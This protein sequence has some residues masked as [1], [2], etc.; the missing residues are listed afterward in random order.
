M[1]AI[2]TGAD[3]VAWQN[4]DIVV[5]FIARRLSREC[6]YRVDVAVLARSRISFLGSDNPGRNAA[7]YGATMD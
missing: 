4:L 3:A 6:R 7:R 1:H 5:G 2:L